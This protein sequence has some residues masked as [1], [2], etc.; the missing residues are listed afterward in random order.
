[1]AVYTLVQSLS[2][3]GDIT[4]QLEDIR[5]LW[6]WDALSGIARHR[7]DFRESF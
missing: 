6:E 1:M 2:T 7:A 4:A 3:D 5:R